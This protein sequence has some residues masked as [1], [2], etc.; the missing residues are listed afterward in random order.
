MGKIMTNQTRTELEPPESLV[1]SGNMAE[2][3][4]TDFILNYMSEV[5]AVAE[6]ILT[7]KQHMIELDKKRQ[8]SREAIRVLQ[9]DKTSTKQWV[10]FGNMFI[11]MPSKETKLLLEKGLSLFKHARMST[12]RKENQFNCKALLLRSTV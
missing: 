7:S 1:R 6:E 11:K 9:K 5:E 2:K 4:E 8:K 3:N 10:C 12:M